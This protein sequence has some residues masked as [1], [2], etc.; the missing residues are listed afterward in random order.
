MAYTPEQLVEVLERI[1]KALELIVDK[2]DE[3]ASSIGAK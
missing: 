3:I 1:A 2:L